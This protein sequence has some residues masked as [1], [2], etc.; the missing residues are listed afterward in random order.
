MRNKITFTMLLA[1][2]LLL[3]SSP[4]LAQDTD[5]YA[6]ADSI[7]GCSV[8]P[9]YSGWI[10]VE[11]VHHL[12]FKQEA[13]SAPPQKKQYILTRRMDCSTIDFWQALRQQTHINEIELHAVEETGEQPRLTQIIRL[14]DVRIESIETADDFLDE[15]PM[16]RIRF[17]YTSLEIESKCYDHLGDPC[18]DHQFQYSFSKGKQQ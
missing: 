12:W 10:D 2:A 16:E 18:A 11:A 5:W 3:L 7:G 8:A 1:G 9:N 17:S 6:Q 13:Q 4:L 14:Q 15:P